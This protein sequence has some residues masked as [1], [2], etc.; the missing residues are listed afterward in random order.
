MTTQIKIDSEFVKLCRSM[1]EAQ[2][3]AKF[4]QRDQ[5]RASSLEQIFDA[6]LAKIE[7]ELKAAEK[8]AES[9]QLQFDVKKVN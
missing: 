8:P 6:K 2:K 4:N 5:R 7:T 1:R 9:E 3:V